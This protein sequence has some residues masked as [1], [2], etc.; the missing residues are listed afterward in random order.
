MRKAFKFR[1]YPTR[2]QT[3]AL[4]RML[5]THRH[6]YNSALAER[7]E[8]WDAEQRSVSYGEQSG[9]LKADRLT[10]PYLAETNFSSTQA[11]LRR[12]DKAFQAFYR[13][14]KK[15]EK[16][17]YPRFKG[18]NRFSTVEFLSYGDGCK[19]DAISSR[20]Y[21]QHIGWVKVKLH[22]LVER[23]VKTV[24]LKR[25]PDGW[26]VIFSC[27]LGD[28]AVEPSANPAVGIDLGLKSFLVT[29]N[30]L[31]VEPPKFYRQA[32][33]A[34]RRAQRLVSRRKKF[35]NRRR[36]AIR[37]VACIHQHIT[38]QRRDFHHK[39]ALALTRGYGMIAHENLNIKGIVK[40]RLAK[41]TYDAGWA[42]FLTI[43]HSKAE[44]A[45]VKVIGVPPY[46]TSQICSECGNLVPKTL[47]N[48]VHSCPHCGYEANRDL[49]AAR[50]I[51]RLGLSHQALTV[52]I[53]AVA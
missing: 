5:D 34:L 41:S 43:L 38:N 25:E 44:W 1:L 52:A 51:L 9:H 7:K 21:F 10:N 31:N 53:A 30:G 22:R 29:S 23:R 33:A 27:D 45:G 11:T 14:V 19:L 4:T 17:G 35:S 13:R 24:S 37:L 32:Q 47:A 49:N 36:N 42:G 40:T 15:G 2:Q 50:N 26:H 28:V 6:L 12:L 46:N 8:T 16:P 3:D 39:T 20:V 48:R 18:F